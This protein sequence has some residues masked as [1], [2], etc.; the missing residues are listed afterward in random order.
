MGK[1]WGFPYD[2]KHIT[3]TNIQSQ[4][5]KQNC[6]VHLE[7]REVLV[8]LKESQ[9]QETLVCSGLSVNWFYSMGQGSKN[10]L[11]VF[12]NILLKQLILE[13]VKGNI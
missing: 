12:C 6:I 5:C 9:V 4:K 8:Y 13:N 10:N 11:L 7:K 3:C 1:Y 2:Y